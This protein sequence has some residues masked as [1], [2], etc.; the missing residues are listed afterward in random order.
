MK[1]NIKIL[2]LEYCGS[3]KV[4]GYWLTPGGGGGGGWELVPCALRGQLLKTKISRLM[5]KS[6]CGFNVN[7]SG[8]NKSILPNQI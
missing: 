1:M 5:K 4:Y 6:D 7:N 3:K 2:I 8:V